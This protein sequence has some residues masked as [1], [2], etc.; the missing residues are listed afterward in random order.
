MRFTDPPLNGD[1]IPPAGHRILTPRNDEARSANGPGR[2]TTMTHWSDR[3]RLLTACDPLLKWA[4]TQES[5]LASWR[6]CEDGGWLLWIAATLDVDRR[7]IVTAACKCARLALPHVSEGED[8]PLKAIEAAERWVDGLA[9]IEEVRQAAYAAYAAESTASAAYAADAA[10]AAA[11]TAAYGAAYAAD[12][13]AYADA[14]SAAVDAD[15]AAAAAAADRAADAAYA[16]APA[17]YAAFAAYNTVLRQCADIVRSIISE[18]VMLAAWT[19]EE[20]AQWHDDK[21][22]GR[23]RIDE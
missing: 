2:P 11:S 13:A 22:D 7:L 12:A 8:R 15:A 21:G 14:A 1:G 18:D 16:A 4:A 3:L 9:T 20:D 6:S 5:P 19:D 10:R 23:E 17:G